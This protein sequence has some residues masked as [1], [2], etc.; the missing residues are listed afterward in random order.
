MQVFANPITAAPM[1][2]QQPA[3]SSTQSSSTTSDSNSATV[4]AN[5]FLQLLVTEMKNQDPTSTTDPNEYINQL[6]QVNSLEQLISI[7]QDLS[8]LAEAAGNTGSSGS[9]SGGTG[10][11]VSG[12]QAQ[13][14]AAPSAAAGNLSATDTGGRASHIANALS[15]AAKTLA[16]GGNQAPMSGA[17]QSLR[18]RAEQ[19]HTFVSNP[20]H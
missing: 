2:A 9:G 8:P 12:V 6:V 7:N 11:A 13:S 17:I 20:A 19:A 14:P 16:P 5:D 3:D 18:S 15:T 10:G 1:A 4:T